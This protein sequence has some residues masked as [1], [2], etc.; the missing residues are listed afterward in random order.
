MIHI[1]NECRYEKNSYGVL[2]IPVWKSISVEIPEREKLTST[3]GV[4]G[5]VV[6]MPR[7]EEGIF[8]KFTS[9]R[10][11]EMQQG[12][13]SDGQHFYHIADWYV[14]NTD[15]IANHESFERSCAQMIVN[16]EKLM[17]FLDDCQ[18]QA[19]RHY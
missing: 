14:G 15:D 3:N 12:G 9:V 17:A 11:L 4:A 19:D 2:S 10:V 7:I 5:M 1:K 13:F 16:G 8:L 6:V 18:T